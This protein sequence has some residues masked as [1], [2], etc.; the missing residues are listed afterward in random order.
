MNRKDII[1]NQI[2]IVCGVKNESIQR[3][4]LS[5]PELTHKKAVE[6]AVALETLAKQVKD[7]GAKNDIEDRSLTNVN[8]VNE[9]QRSGDTD[10]HNDCYR[11]GGK[12]RAS[13]CLW[14]ANCFKIQQ[15]IFIQLQQLYSH[16]SK[17]FIQLQQLYSHS[18]KILI[19]LQQLY[20]HSSK[21][22]IQLQQLYSHSRKILIQLQQLYSHSRK[23]FIQLHQSTI[24]FTFKKNIYSTSRF[25]FNF[26]L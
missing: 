2:L 26:K 15:K 20:S 1:F 7:L 18:R 4:L 10:R 9:T 14:F 23:I 8:K 25:L 22:F 24:G 5:E 17:I 19:Q 16:S 13:S 12:H 3:R 11:C 21:I 6:I